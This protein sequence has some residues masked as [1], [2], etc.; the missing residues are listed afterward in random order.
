MGR[1]EPGEQKCWVRGADRSVEHVDYSE[2]HDQE[3]AQSVDQCATQLP[4]ISDTTKR[5]ENLLNC[6]KDK[7]W[8]AAIPP[9]VYN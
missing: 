3:A 7:G 4:R 9:Q 8:S 6:M 5:Q 1:I 2:C